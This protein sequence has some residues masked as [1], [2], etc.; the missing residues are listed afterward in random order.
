MQ[1]KNIPTGTHQGLE[2]HH[3]LTPEGT[4][5]YQF[6]G[7]LFGAG[8]GRCRLCGRR[9]LDCLGRRAVGRLLPGRAVL[10]GRWR[11]RRR[12]RRRRLGGLLARLVLVVVGGCGWSRRGR[13]DR[14][15]A[16]TAGRGCRWFAVTADTERRWC[17]GSDNCQK[18]A[19]SS[20]SLSQISPGYSTRAG[21]GG[22]NDIPE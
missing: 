13:P 3:C 18:G 12:R 17:Q 8:R 19:R 6:L 2:M 15:A 9:G 22:G 10:G 1:K 21:G 16:A 4:G 14:A 5:S 11:G 20:R 7:L